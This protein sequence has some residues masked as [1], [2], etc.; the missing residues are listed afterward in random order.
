MFLTHS[1]LVS[2]ESWQNGAAVQD[3][4]LRMKQN[5]KWSNVT[6]NSYRKALMSYF[7]ALEDAD[8]VAKNPI[9]KIRKCPEAPKDQPKLRKSDIE[10]LFRELSTYR[11]GVSYLLFYRNYLFFLLSY[12]TGARPVEILDLKIGSFSADRSVIR[13]VGAK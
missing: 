8:I 5:R 1:D 11:P 10:P 9:R 2:I 6:Y 7:Q 12:Y 3:S 4:F 13:I